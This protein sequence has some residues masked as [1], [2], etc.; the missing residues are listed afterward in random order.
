MLTPTAMPGIHF[1]CL[2]DG[3]NRYVGC[4]GVGRCQ[5]AGTPR[6]LLG[7]WASL[8]YRPKALDNPLL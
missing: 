5:Q 2:P 3:T 8:P 6:C 4:V 1:P 7:R